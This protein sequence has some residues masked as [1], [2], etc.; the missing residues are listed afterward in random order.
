MARGAV[1]GAQIGLLNIA[2]GRVSGTQIGLINVATASTF[3]LGL[4]NIFRDGRLHLDV[5]GQESGLLMAGIK[6]GSG[7]FHNIYGAGVLPF[8]NHARFAAAFGIGAHLPLSE[9]L[10]LDLDVLNHGLFDPA[11]IDATVNLAQARAVLGARLVRRLAVYGGPS[12]N[13]AV[14]S[15]GPGA[16][17]EPL[18][19]QLHQRRRERGRPGLARDHPRRTGLV[20]APRSADQGEGSSTRPRKRIVPVALSRIK[21]RYAWSRWISASGGTDVVPT[22][23]PVA[24]AASVPASS[25][26]MNAL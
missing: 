6:H 1:S 4:I 23:A 15:N 22:T 24:A 16:G 21:N 10:F 13:V 19:A 11:S 7:H 8:G 5:W 3:S 20:R 2:G 9:R 26:W 18:W 14:S 17:A 12:Y 25:T